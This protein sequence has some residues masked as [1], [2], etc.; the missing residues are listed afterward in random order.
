[1]ERI[2]IYLHVN[3]ICDVITR[4]CMSQLSAIFLDIIIGIAHFLILELDIS[5]S[6]KMKRSDSISRS[7]CF[8]RCVNSDL[9]S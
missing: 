9:T 6:F 7:I 8:D 2:K 3:D 4:I 1:M 5:F